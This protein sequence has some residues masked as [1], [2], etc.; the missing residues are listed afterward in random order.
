MSSSQAPWWQPW[1]RWP[2]SALAAE[3]VLVGLIGA[4]LGLLAGGRQDAAI[5]PVQTRMSVVPSL[6]GGSV[7]AVPPL[8]RLTIDTHDGPWQLDAEVTRINAGDARRI[9][10]DPSSL[11]GLPE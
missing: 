11:N 7:V 3:I 10:N 5:G 2:R 9:F 8:G 1:R 6:H 4:W